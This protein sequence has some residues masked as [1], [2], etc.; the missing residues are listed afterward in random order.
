MQRGKKW[1]G[2]NGVKA[3][4]ERE[5]EGGKRIRLEGDGDTGISG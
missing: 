5:G 2:D 3:E 4:K 1:Q